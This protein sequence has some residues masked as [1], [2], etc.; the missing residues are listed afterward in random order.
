MEHHTDLDFLPLKTVDI[1][2]KFGES[3]FKNKL[4][5]KVSYF[6]EHTFDG[7]ININLPISVYNGKT[8]FGNTS[9]DSLLSKEGLDKYKCIQAHTC[10]SSAFQSDDEGKF[11]GLAPIYILKP[12]EVGRGFHHLKFFDTV[13]EANNFVTFMQTKVVNFTYICGVVGTCNSRE[14]YRYIPDIDDFTIIY[15]DRPLNGYTPDRY[16]EYIDRDGNKH[17]S[18]YVKYKLTDDEIKVIESVIRERK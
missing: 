4:N 8:L 16:G 17:C 18:L 11:L 14:F 10:G 12:Y 6:V 15:E 2:H 9:E 5:H 13:E 1:L 7:G 3:D